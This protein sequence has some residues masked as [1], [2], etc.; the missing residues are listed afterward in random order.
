MNPDTYQLMHAKTIIVS[1]FEDGKSN[2]NSSS[3]DGRF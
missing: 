3:S 1:V 2:Q